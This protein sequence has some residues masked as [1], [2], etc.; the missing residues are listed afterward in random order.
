MARWLV[1]C[2]VCG[3]QGIIDGA[4]APTRMNLD[5]TLEE[6]I[7]YENELTQQ[8]IEQYTEYCCGRAE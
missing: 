8:Y 6:A 5:I 3:Q 1:Y 4:D 7:E 2:E